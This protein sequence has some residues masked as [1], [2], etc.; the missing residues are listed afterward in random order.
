VP[1]EVQEGERR[2]SIGTYY[3]VHVI[4]DRWYDISFIK[5][6]ELSEIQ[7]PDEDYPHTK[8]LSL[9]PIHTSALGD[10]KFEELYNSK[11]IKFFNP[12]QT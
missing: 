3:N 2:I 5:Q 1:Y 12:V 4:S 11:N 7:V 8:L 6:I 10:E 9:R